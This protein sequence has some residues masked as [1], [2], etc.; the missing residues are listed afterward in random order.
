MG[1]AG[2]VH[3]MRELFL[4]EVENIKSGILG[5][6]PEHATPIPIYRENSITVEAVR[7]AFI[8]LKPI[9]EASC[10]PVKIKET[11][12]SRDP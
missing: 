5:S 1:I 9:R 2:A 7:V 4:L 12:A 6:Y 3:V 10:L 11:L 8:V